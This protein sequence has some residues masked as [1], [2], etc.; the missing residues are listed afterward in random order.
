MIYI[1]IYI[2]IYLY[3]YTYIYIHTYIHTYIHI[4]ILYIE[5]CKGLVSVV[6]NW[7]GRFQDELDYLQEVDS[8]EKFKSQVYIYT[9][10]YI[11]I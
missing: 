2:Y 1:Y 11:Y 4:Y 9:Y 10:I 7:A 5:E 8:S 6:D 3:V